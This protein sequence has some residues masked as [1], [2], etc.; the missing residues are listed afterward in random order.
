[1]AFRKIIVAN[2]YLISV[3]WFAAGFIWMFM[4]MFIP[5]GYNQLLPA[6]FFTISGNC[7]LWLANHVS[8]KESVLKAPKQKNEVR[9]TQSISPKQQ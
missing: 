5:A 1:M 3:I 2:L 9:E 7:V 4:L 6:F 8:G